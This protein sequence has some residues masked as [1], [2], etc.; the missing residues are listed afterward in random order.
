MVENQ[1]LLTPKSRHPL[2]TD[3][4]PQK[5]ILN[6]DIPAKMKAASMAFIFCLSLLPTFAQ[7]QQKADSAL[8]ILNSSDP[9]KQTELYLLRLISGQSTKPGDIV[10]YSQELIRKSIDYQDSLGLIRGYTNLGVG[11]KLM[12]DLQKSIETFYKLRHLGDSLGEPLISSDALANIAFTH[13]SRNEFEKAKDLE[14]EVME[15]YNSRSLNTG[16]IDSSRSSANYLNIG[17]TYYYLGQYDSALLHLENCLRVAKHALI[18]QYA[19]ATIALVLGHQGKLDSAESLLKKTLIQLDAKNDFYGISECKVQF[20][21]ALV[22]N[23]EI[24]KGINYTEKGY[25]MALENG[26]KEQIQDGAKI[27][28]EAYRRL[29]DYPQALAFQTQYYNYRDSLI[30]AESIQRIADQRTA[31]EVGLKQSEVDL[32]QSQKETQQAILI[33]LGIFL[34]LLLILAVIIYYFYQSKNKLSKEL[35]LQKEELERLNKTKDKFF[36]IISHDLRSPVAAFLGVSRMIKILVQNNQTE[37]LLEMSEEINQSVDRLSSLLDNLLNWALQQ[38]G[39]FPNVPEKIH[40]KSIIED[41]TSIFHNMA[42]SKNIS[43]HSEIDDVINLWADRNSTATIFRNILSNALKFTPTDGNINIS[44]EPLSEKCIVIF[45][46][47]GIGMDQKKI[48][49]V[50]QNKNSDSSYGTAGEKGLGLGLQLVS[51]FVKMNGGEMKIESEN[52]KGT[53]FTIQ[54]PLF[55]EESVIQ[56]IE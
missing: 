3:S 12:G 5:S 19:S 21:S 50:L 26:L 8:Q 6:F 38:Q 16:I 11:Y 42:R 2:T 25:R 28:S 49:L 52:K 33:S 9:D 37:D 41:Q 35:S 40:L 43:I 45:K 24:K 48:E 32:L 56:K 51:E 46:D 7:N 22:K 14:I 36:S 55:V 47:S 54:L 34:F 23:G 1:L 44:A 13:K 18:D 39:H 29:G 30:N 15:I 17:N 31:Y 4:S 20:G 10:F 53:T 27:L